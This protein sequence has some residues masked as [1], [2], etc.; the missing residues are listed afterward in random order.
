MT[1]RDSKIYRVLEVLDPNRD[2]EE[3]KEG[4]RVRA[5]SYRREKGS[6]EAEEMLRSEYRNTRN[7]SK[8]TGIVGGTL[9]ALGI[10][11]FTAPL[12]VP[13]ILVYGIA[14]LVS[15]V[16]C[17]HSKL[18]LK[19]IKD[20]LKEEE[21]RNMEQEYPMEEVLGNMLEGEESFPLESHLDFS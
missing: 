11:P 16:G 15:L 8:G 5:E 17:A 19:D 20:V 18:S 10:C 2:S 12:L 14:T 13:Y 9:L 3:F 1:E 21:T 7:A 4:L 6:L